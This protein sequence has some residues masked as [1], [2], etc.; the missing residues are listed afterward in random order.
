MMPIWKRRSSQSLGV[1][2]LIFLGEVI[3]P[4][5]IARSVAWAGGRVHMVGVG[6][7][8]LLAQLEGGG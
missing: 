6:L 7:E 8:P 1:N 3:E 2:I 4:S 5:A